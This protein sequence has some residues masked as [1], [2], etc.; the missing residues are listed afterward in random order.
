MTINCKGKLVD[1]SSPVVM[2]ILNVTPDSFYD[3]GQ[4]VTSTAIKQ[5]VQ[6]MVAD[7]AT[8]IDVGG[9]SSRP[10]ATMISRQEEIDRVSPAIEIIVQHMPDVVISIDTLHSEVAAHCIR[11]GATMVNDISAGD[12]D[13]DMIPTVAEAGVPYVAMHMQ[14][15]P[16]N[17]QDDPQYHDVV[18]E[19]LTYFAKKVRQ[20]RAAGIT[21]VILDPGFGFGKSLE[22]N[23][24]LLRHLGSLGILDCPLLAGLSRKSMIYKPLD[25]TAAD[26][27]TG[28]SA[29]HM[30]ALQQ[31][32]SI[33]RVHD[34]LEAAQ[35]IQLHELLTSIK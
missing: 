31:G 8:I 28:T 3:G 4:A 25:I 13:A 30:V 10:G 12:Y 17:M 16:S 27:L 5:K 7:G 6:Q 14:G 26:A 1:L 11:M 32:A 34:V 24:A 29:L 19:V 18:M 2:G 15:L 21:D 9:M 20:C 33:L 35:C 22:H 23:Y